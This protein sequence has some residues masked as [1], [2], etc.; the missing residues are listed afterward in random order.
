MA[1]RREPDITALDQG[2]VFRLTPRSDR[3]RDW[4]AANVRVGK[5]D[6]VGV[7]VSQRQPCG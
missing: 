6:G 3:A 1:T 4:L 5:Q 7:V 2:G